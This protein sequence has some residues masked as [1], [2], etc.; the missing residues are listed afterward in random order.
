[1]AETPPVPVNLRK[2]CVDTPGRMQQLRSWLIEGKDCEKQGDLHGAL[3][4]FGDA[5]TMLPDDER[6]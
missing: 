3:L 5:L 1:M 2:V 4:A 6:L